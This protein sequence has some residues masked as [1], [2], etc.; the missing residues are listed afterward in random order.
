M[1]VLMFELSHNLG[2]ERF[3]GFKRLL[4]NLNCYQNSLLNQY[5]RQKETTQGDPS[6]VILSKGRLTS[7]VFQGI[8]ALLG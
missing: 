5:L 4:R 8:A 1:I 3:H 7:K 6:Q 2:Q